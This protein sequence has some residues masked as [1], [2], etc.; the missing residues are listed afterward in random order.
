MCRALIAA[1]KSWIHPVPRVGGVCH[2]VAQLSGRQP[3]GK[4]V[5][6]HVWVV[7]LEDR[8][9]RWGQYPLRRRARAAASEIR[10]RDAYLL[11]ICCV[12]A[13]YHMRI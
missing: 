12:F 4:E 5:G 6:W 7:D 3:L 11:R 1:S 10:M 13:M 9:L 8:R 2:A